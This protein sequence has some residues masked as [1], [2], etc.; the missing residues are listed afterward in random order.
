MFSGRSQ[1]TGFLMVSRAVEMIH[2]DGSGAE[3]AGPSN[4][5][6]KRNAG[7]A[8]S[9]GGTRGGVCDPDGSACAT[10]AGSAAA[11]RPSPDMNRRFLRS[12]SGTA[13]R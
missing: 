1:N 7:V 2:F 3:P 10:G 11:S 6:W 12:I 5:S 9:G 13:T 8:V 4:S